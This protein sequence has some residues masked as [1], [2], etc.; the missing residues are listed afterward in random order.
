M[1]PVSYDN[2]NPNYFRQWHSQRAIS[3]PRPGNYRYPQNSN[4]VRPFLHNDRNRT[5]VSRPSAPNSTTHVH[6]QESLPLLP[7]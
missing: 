5:R 1:Y 7:M 3:N 4:A 6:F 2:L